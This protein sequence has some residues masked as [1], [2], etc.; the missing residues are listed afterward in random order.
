MSAFYPTARPLRPYSD[1]ADGREG[2]HAR[3][4]HPHEHARDP[5]IDHPRP[6]LPR[7]CR[8]PLL[9]HHCCHTVPAAWAHCHYADDVTLLLPAPLLSR[10]HADATTPRLPRG[11]PT[12]YCCCCQA[13]AAATLLLS[14]CGCSTAP[15]LSPQTHRD[16]CSAGAGPAKN[17]FPELHCPKKR[18]SVSVEIPDVFALSVAMNMISSV[19]GKIRK[20]LSDA[21]VLPSRA[22]RRCSL[23]SRE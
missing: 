20:L 4:A 10:Y 22:T 15:D 19:T 9:P 21:G 6:A 23:R 13:A 2:E 14:H 7:C 16:T 11:L 1:P 3:S 12:P 8:L 18:S 17:E 5:L